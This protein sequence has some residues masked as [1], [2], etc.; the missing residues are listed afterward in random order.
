MD[1]EAALK[2]TAFGTAF[3]Q[4]RSVGKALLRQRKPGGTDP[5]LSFKVL[6]KGEYVE[7]EGGPYRQFFTDVSK[8][9]QGQLPLLVP[10]PN[11]QAKIGENRD[12]FVF[13]PGRDSALDMAMYEF[14]GVLMGCALRTGGTLPASLSLSLSAPLVSRPEPFSAS[15]AGPAL[16]CL[17]AARGSPA[18]ARGPLQGTSHIHKRILSPF[19]SQRARPDDNSPLIS[20]DT[21]LLLL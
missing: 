18:R 20:R 13:A 9:L 12:K 19:A 2:R 17:E 1:C 14:L 4:L 6:F 16:V 7:G 3:E 11:A 10:C 15:H 5:H 8:E 21:T